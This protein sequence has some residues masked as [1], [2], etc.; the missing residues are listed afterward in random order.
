MFEKFESEA[1]AF[2]CAFY[3]AR[4][5]CNDDLVV[6]A[7]VRLERSE[8]VIGDAAFGGS[9]FIEE[10]R[11]TRIR[12][13]D[14]SDI[15][16]EPKLK[17]EFDDVTLFPFLEILRRRVGRGSELIVASAAVAAPC[18]KQPFAHIRYLFAESRLKVHDRRPC[19]NFHYH[20]FAS[21]AVDELPAAV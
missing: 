5:V 10:T 12:Q 16:D 20:V 19:R 9:E 4:N 3:E 21:R 7:E 13:S 1:F 2:R 6:C 17:T 11:L 14:K 18:G 8:C 15:G